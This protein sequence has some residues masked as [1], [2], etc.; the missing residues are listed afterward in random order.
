M[1]KCEEA[2]LVFRQ[3]LAIQEKVLGPEDPA[4]VATRACIADL[5]KNLSG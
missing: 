3:V 4:A 2:E 5:S 1:R